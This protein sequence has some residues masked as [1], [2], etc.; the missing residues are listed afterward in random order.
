[1]A[2]LSPSEALVFPLSRGA[3]PAIGF[4]A[5]GLGTQ[6]APGD[7]DRSARIELMDLALRS[8]DLDLDGDGVIDDGELDLEKNGGKATDF[9]ASWRTYNKTEY[10]QSFTPTRSMRH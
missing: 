8:V 1:M 7:K 10:D 3:A 6:G 2:W 9:R 5:G 4:G